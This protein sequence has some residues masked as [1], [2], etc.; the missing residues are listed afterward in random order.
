MRKLLLFIALPLVVLPGFAQSRDCLRIMPVDELIRG[1]ILIG[2]VKVLKTDKARYRGSYGQVGVLLPVDIIDGDFTMTEINVLARSNV[3]CAED[4]Y[5][6]DQE[7]L[8]FLEPEDSLFHTV[9]Y[10]FGQFVIEREVVKGWRDKNNN[11]VDKP[12]AEVRQEILKCLIKVRHPQLENSTKPPSEG[13]KTAAPP[14]KPPQP[15]S[16]QSQRP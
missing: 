7:M 1:S 5:K 8:V 14:A 2:R 13:Q 6:R 15:S 10:Q 4:N 9:N 16:G 12:Y 11:A 3:R